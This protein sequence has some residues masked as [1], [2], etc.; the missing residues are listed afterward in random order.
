MNNIKQ[1]ENLFVG[2][3]KACQPRIILNADVTSQ[4]RLIKRD[5]ATKVIS[6]TNP[7]SLWSGTTAM[8][9][10]A[11]GYLY[12][13]SQ[14]QAVQICAISGPDIY[15]SYVEIDNKVYVSNK[16]WNTIFDPSDDTTS[17]WGLTL[18]EQSLVSSTSGNLPA[19]TYQV[20]FTRF[21]NREISGNGPI[22]S[23]ELTSE[24]GISI[25]NRTADSLV[26]ITDPNGNKF[27]LAGQLDTIVNTAQSSE[28]LPSFLCSPPPYMEYL[29]HAFGRVWGNVD[30]VLYYSEP[31][32]PDWFR[33]QFNKFEYD[34]NI[35][36]IAPVPT[37]IFV[38]CED[39]TY[40]L[41]GTEPG[42]MKQSV[43]GK[44]AVPGTLKYC[45][46]VPELGDILSPAERIHVSV[47]IWLSQ[48]G[49]VIGNASGRLFN[50]TQQKVKFRPGKRGAS[51]H[52]MKNGE[53]QYLTSFKQGSPGSGFG[54]ADTVT[55]EV[56][57]NG[58][59]LPVKKKAPPPPIKTF[60]FTVQTTGASETF[61]LPLEA[62][63]TYN[64]A[65]SWGDNSSDNITV[66]NQAEV[67]HTYASAGT[68][69]IKITGTIVGWRFN[70][71]GDY[72][73][74]YEIKS[75]G[76]LKLGNNGRYFYGCANL[77]IT[78]TDV[79]DLTGTTDL[80]RMLAECTSLTTIPSM[81]SWDISSV[82]IMDYM[83][84]WSALFNQDIS[85][86]NTVSVM[87]MSSMFD[88]ATSFDQNIGPWP[89]ISVTDMLYMFDGVT[90][91]TANYDALLIG[92]EAQAVQN[93]V[94]FHGGNSKYSAGA[95][96]TARA[97][98]IAD[99]SWTITD[100]GP[101]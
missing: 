73:K 92:W 98:L 19:G 33:T 8:L 62:T 69:E 65:V 53:F 22:A 59:V 23:I 61:S 47:P 91:S 48:E 82:I 58:S 16:Y 89:I 45:N 78:A 50:L 76:P 4:G 35:T 93:N 71:S 81:N 38:G 43:V 5:G 88:N 83:F 96:A 80:T 24:G 29:S 75:W 30:K 3:E 15:L 39:T 7:H 51:V 86:W 66:Y 55:A 49:I 99:H 46:N 18:P 31:F 87:S 6:L 25:S 21:N 67:T 90:L 84:I 32:H 63:G 1:S 40:F 95:A 64:F 41:A 9:C 36:L 54:M 2:R 70:Y 27:F 101:A 52:R 60:I 20:C 17:D 13:I 26:W 74:I 44:G 37:G 10:A 57:R 100:G 42:Q 72:A 79:L 34:Q 77:T 97:A 11:G 28:P 12:R 85:S 68:Y 14:G 56:I 94:T